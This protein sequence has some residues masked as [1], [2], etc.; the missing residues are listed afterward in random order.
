MTYI[1]QGVK[2][3]YKATWR[4]ANPRTIIQKVIRD[5]PGAGEKNHQK[6]FMD[7]IRDDHDQLMATAAYYFDLNYKYLTRPPR[8]RASNAEAR[9]RRKKTVAS[10]TSHIKQRIK[11]EAKLL[12]MDLLM[13]NNKPLGDCTGA[14]CKRF[15]GWL[16]KL[17]AV[18]PAKKTV[19]ETLSEDELHR[20]W[21]Q[22]RRK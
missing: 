22:Q 18:V 2:G 19:R 3:A 11:D 9:E 4:D 16:A 1:E 10:A 12:L 21:Q 7:E 13:P 6:M 14:D 15:D 5:N 20:L 8:T 17:A